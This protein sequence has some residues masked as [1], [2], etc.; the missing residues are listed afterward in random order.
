MK[1]RF[2]AS[3]AMALL[4]VAP[5][6]SQAADNIIAIGTGAVTG[7][8]Y[9]A[10]GA[11]CR[12]INRA[13]KEHGIRCFVES[14]GGSVYN[15]RALRD[16]EISFGI[17][18][19]DW[20]YNAYRGKGAFADGPPFRDLRSVMSL[21]SEMFTVA[22]AK[23]SGIQSFADLQGKRVNIGDPGSGMHEIMES[24][25]ESKKWTKHSFAKAEELKPTDAAK[26]LCDGAI[27]AMV[28]A[29]GH[30]NGLIQEVTGNCG[31]RLIPV[32]GSEVDKLLKDTPFY[33]RNAI[34]GGMYQNNPQNIPTFGVKA[35]LVTTSD[36]DDETVYQLTKAVFD[37]FDSFKTLHFVFATLDKDKMVEAG[38]VAPLHP[39]ALRYYKENKL[40]SATSDG[41]MVEDE[42]KTEDE[43]TDN[44]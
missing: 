18:Q 19:S 30:P 22:V 34:P 26:A 2:I 5:Q 9:P 13:R 39:G 8:Y 10:G 28:F 38:L 36:V 33:A 14:T 4:L 25:M 16:G 11:I 20:Q 3:C 6:P 21:H 42:P 27:D 37:N 15:I 32:Q 40:I 24:L 44:E 41:K 29:A 12:L 43:S 7:V 23:D 1:L 35:T 17:V 31:A